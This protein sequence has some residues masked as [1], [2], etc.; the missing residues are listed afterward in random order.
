M[1]K[2]CSD[3]NL[4]RISVISLHMEDV[5]KRQD[6]RTPFW[7][8]SLITWFTHMA[9]QTAVGNRPLWRRN[10]DVQPNL[11]ELNHKKKEMIIEY[12]STFKSFMY[13]IYILE[14][15]EGQGEKSV[16]RTKN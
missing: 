7:K 6:F 12:F 14:N 1:V 8:V 11:T 16:V 9:S 10:V 13:A 4:N 3:T 5:V 15:Q 2:Y